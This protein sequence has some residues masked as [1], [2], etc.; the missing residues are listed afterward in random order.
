MK[1]LIF[2]C[3]CFTA[4]AAGF[5]PNPTLT[6]LAENTGL[7]LGAYTCNPPV[8]DNSYPC[9]NITD[10]SG[11]TYD[12]DNNRMLMFGGG[13]AT[14]M[15]D[16]LVEFPMSTLTWSPLYTSTPC[17][18]M[19][20]GNL[21][22]TRAAWLSGPS[23][24]FPRPVSRHTYDNLIA[25]PGLGEFINLAECNGGQSI[26]PQGFDFS[27][28]DP[29]FMS[30]RVAHYV[31]QSGTWTFSATAGGGEVPAGSQSYPSI[32]Y[33]PL[34]GQVIILGRYGLSTY[35]PVAKTKVRHIR[36]DWGELVDSAGNYLSDGELRGWCNLVYFPP[37]QRHYYFNRYYTPLRVYELQLDRTNWDQST[38]T[39]MTV[40]GTPPPSRE[41][42]FD[43]DSVNQIIGG[44][45]ANDRFYA[46]DPAAH[47]WTEKTIQGGSP[48][49]VAFH[50]LSYDPV[51]NVFIFLTQARRTWAYRF[52][53][54]GTGTQRPAM[55]AAPVTLSAE[56]NPFRSAVTI[57]VKTLHLKEKG[58]QNDKCNVSTVSIYD[59]HGRTVHYA[60]DLIND[61]TI[62]N[63]IGLSPGLYIIRARIGSQIIEKKITL[64]K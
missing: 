18:N 45:V 50:A 60:D 52:G 30:G 51:N 2:A 36:G 48:G 8:G 49:T 57:S 33:D 47:S 13:H 11:F 61:A 5:T 62:W 43:Y 46:Y 9:V 58:L 3:F 25:P 15:T 10:Y 19:T 7:D 56:P 35:D 14:T 59:I 55:A 20:P 41:S 22:R 29:F 23:G 38:V 16:E 63:P 39:Q 32:S 31:Y 26:C 54:G 64:L 42:G 44:G 28:G 34:S 21:D 6:G 1:I 40:T 27:S 53:T 37:N 24:P 12:A 4:L 17:A